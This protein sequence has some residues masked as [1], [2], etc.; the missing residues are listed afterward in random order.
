MLGRS[1]IYALA[2]QGQAGVEKPTRSI[3]KKEMRVAMTL[4]GAKSI[5]DLNR[6]SLVNID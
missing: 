1:Y 5:Q 2:A 6:D 3:R 4:T